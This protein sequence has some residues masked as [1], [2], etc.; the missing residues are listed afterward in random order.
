MCIQ[1]P[2]NGALECKV[3]GV[4]RMT[5]VTISAPALM[6][7]ESGVMTLTCDAELVSVARGGPSFFNATGIVEEVAEEVVVCDEDSGVSLYIDDV[8]GCPSPMTSAIN[9]SNC[10]WQSS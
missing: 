5:V 7:D 3:D 1:D 10:H 6:T 4:A 2:P 9:Q 8:R